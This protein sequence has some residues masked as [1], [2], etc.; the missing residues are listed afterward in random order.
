MKKF[1]QLALILS[2]VFLLGFPTI[3]NLFGKSFE[4]KDLVGTWDVELTEMGMLMQFIFKIED[5]ILKGS[6]EFDQ[7][8][9]TMEDIAFTDNKLTFAVSI[10]AG[11]QLMDIDVEATVTE[12]EMTGTMFT[13][14]GDAGFT[15]KK[16]T[17]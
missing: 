10:D 17:L 9:G 16:T 13:E 14:M 11:G 1:S 2:L 12:E 8:T 15:G 5:D 4:D 7:G 3:S 6:M